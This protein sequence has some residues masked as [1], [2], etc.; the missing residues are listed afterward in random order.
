MLLQEQTQ[1]QTTGSAPMPYA[2][3]TTKESKIQIIPEYHDISTAVMMSTFLPGG[4]QLYNGQTIKG[5]LL[6]VLTFAGFFGVAWI[7]SRFT[8]FLSGM[9]EIVL[10]LGGIFDAAIIARRL[11]RGQVVSAWKWF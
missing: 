8:L 11:R 5:V 4:G 1:E 9:G 2:R 7:P 10:W 3:K 6:I